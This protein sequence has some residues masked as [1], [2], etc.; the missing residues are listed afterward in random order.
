[1]R[2]RYCPVRQYN[3]DKPAKYR[4]DFFLLADTDYYNV[5]HL[6]V[7]QG[8][9]KA[10]IDIHPTLHKLP[11]TQK[12]VANAILKSRID[13]DPNGSRRLLWIIDMLRHNFLH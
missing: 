10:N 11:T 5:F 3:K 2:S 8:S 6:D 7:Y 1:M 9:N 4:V 13:N 12:A